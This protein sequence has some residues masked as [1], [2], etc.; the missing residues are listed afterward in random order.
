LEG[1]IGL[2]WAF[3]RAGAHQVVAALWDVDDTIT[4]GLMDDFY[5]ELKKG[6]T[7]PDALRHAKLTLLHTGGFHAAPYYWAA[8]QLYTRS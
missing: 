5:G 4:P 8:L 2:E 3:M 7:A 1:L 6:K